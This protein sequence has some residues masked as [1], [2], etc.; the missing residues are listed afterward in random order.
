M[1]RFPASVNT[2]T[3][4]SSEQWNIYEKSAFS[5]RRLSTDFWEIP[6]SC[7]FVGSSILCLEA[8]SMSHV[9]NQ[10]CNWK[11]LLLQPCV[12]PRPR[13]PSQSPI[14]NVNDERIN[15]FAFSTEHEGP[16]SILKR[17]LYSAQSMATFTNIKLCC[18]L[19]RSVLTPAVRDFGGWEIASDKTSS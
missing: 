5:D 16:R 9:L 8:F 13:L 6:V 3:N 12:P 2:K 18:V 15:S 4:T 1:H 10:S 11:M 14:K 7:A 19:Y 17:M